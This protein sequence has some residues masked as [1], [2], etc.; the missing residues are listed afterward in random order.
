MGDKNLICTLEDYSKPSHESYRNTIKL[1][2]GNN[3][4]PL[5]SETIRL[6]QNGCSLQ[7]HQSE[8]PKQHL[9]DFLKLVD[10][11]HL[12]GSITTWEDLTTCFLAQFFPPRRTA[13]LRNKILMF[14]QY[15]GESLSEENEAEEESSVKP[16]K[17]GY[18]NR[19]EAD[20]TD[21]VE[22]EK[23][24]NEETK[25]EPREEEGDDPKHFD[26]FPT[27]K[28]LRYH[29]WLLKNP[30]PPRS[31][32]DWDSWYYSSYEEIGRKAHF[33]EDK[34]ILSVGVFSTWMAFRGNTRDL[35]SFGEEMNKITHLNQI[36]KEVL[37][38]ERGDGVAS[39]KRRH[40][41]LFSDGLRNLE[42]A[43]GRGQLIEDLESSTLDNKDAN[44]HIK[45]VQKIVDLFDIPEVTQYQIML[46]ISHMLL[47][48]ATNRWLRN[49]PAGSIATWETLK[50]NFLSKYCPP[51]RTAKKIEEINNFQQEFGET[52]Y[53]AWE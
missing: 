24:F 5:R 8:D 42:I 21:E 7:G 52:L 51:A 23:E 37:L 40:R 30:R 44:E 41:D 12:D 38:T 1:P 2:V 43:S 25:G 36:L 4:V 14:Q 16:R 15:H 3:V 6:V 27:M 49:E 33:L 18:I 9:K 48:R 45:K 28:E 34:Q 26:T 47:T 13:K 50:A 22:I 32:G 46:R 39:I 10:S 20:D 17:T 29:E 53:Q 19:E 35:G 31:W 11:L